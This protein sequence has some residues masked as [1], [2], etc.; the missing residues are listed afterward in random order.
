MKKGKRKDKPEGA[1][2]D[3][4]SDIER[5]NLD[6]FW[7]GKHRPCFRDA[8]VIEKMTV[9]KKEAKRRVRS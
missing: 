2:D 6:L 3:S 5:E 4:D 9:T 1:G 7:E 8:W